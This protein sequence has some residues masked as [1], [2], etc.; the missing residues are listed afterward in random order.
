MFLTPRKDKGKQLI[1]ILKMYLSISLI[2]NNYEIR[3][4]RFY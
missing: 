4:E 1:L 3:S 2:Q